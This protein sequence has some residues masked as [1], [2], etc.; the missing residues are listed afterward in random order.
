ML[1][2][3]VPSF[4]LPFSCWHLK[5]PFLFLYF[6]NRWDGGAGGAVAN[7]DLPQRKERG[8]VQPAGRGQHGGGLLYVSYSHGPLHPHLHL[9]APFLLEAEILL[10]RGLLWKTWNAIHDQQGE[11]IETHLMTHFLCRRPFSGI[12]TCVW[13]PWVGPDLV[14]RVQLSPPLLPV[15]NRST[16]SCFPIKHNR[17]KC[18]NLTLQHWFRLWGTKAR[19]KHQYQSRERKCWAKN[20]DDWQNSWTTECVKSNENW[21]YKL[22]KIWWKSKTNKAKGFITIQFFFFFWCICF[23]FKGDM[24]CF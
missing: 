5:T 13:Q 17:L 2:V 12:Q 11:E 1:S 4:L 6:S 20:I 22:F 19:C 15:W 18:S 8:H 24:S 10:H 21:L 7:W 23:I 14:C 3:S 9:R 16:Q